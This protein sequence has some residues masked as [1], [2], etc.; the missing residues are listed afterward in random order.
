VSN[1][2]WNITADLNLKNVNLISGDNDKQD[3]YFAASTFPNFH[4]RTNDKTMNKYG[5]SFMVLEFQIFSG[6]KGD[7]EW[8]MTSN[9]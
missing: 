4:R 5:K 9:F 6:N 3:G 8:K 2:I 7:L 1:V